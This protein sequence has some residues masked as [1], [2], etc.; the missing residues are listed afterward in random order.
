MPLADA[1]VIFYTNPVFVGIWAALF[2]GER[3]H[4]IDVLGAV[5]SLVGVA[6]IAR[7][8]FLFGG[9]SPLEFTEVAVA[10]T[11]AFVASMAYT[12][13]RKLGQTEEPIVVV[14]WFPLV[15]TPVLLPFAL[16]TGYVPNLPEALILFGIGCATQIAQVRMTQG[17]QL[18]TAARATS[19]TYLQV[20]FAFVWGVLLFGEVPTLFTIAGA[21]VVMGAI[22]LISQYR[23]RQRP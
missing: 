4:R 5:A 15:A 10:L 7:P 22:F 17:L 9:E 13:V 19:M 16:S 18:E 23:R 6:L 1:T 14:F 3:L 20:V 11:A 21:V 8:T 2:L 12:L